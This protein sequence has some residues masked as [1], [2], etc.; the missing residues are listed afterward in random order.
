MSTHTIN[1]SIT[2]TETPITT[3]LVEQQPTILAECLSVVK[4]EGFHM[5]KCIDASL[6]YDAFKHASTMLSELKTTKLLP[7]YYYELYVS[8]FDE[9]R[10]L[11]NYLNEIFKSKSNDL[12]DLYELVQYATSIVPRLYLL[13]T[14][15]SVYMK[16]ANEYY[17]TKL[18]LLPVTNNNDRHANLLNGLA[19]VDLADKDREIPN[20]KKMPPV[21]EIMHDI[22]DMTSG[23]QHA[24]RGLFLRY[25]LSQLT[26]DE[27]PD[28]PESYIPD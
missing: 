23:V 28:I 6:I 16:A 21:K 22:L 17:C 1:S 8:I 3:P 12:S 26:K 4:T 18:I 15:G 10:H 2:E 11:T 20:E 5:R 7:K 24:T 14:V 19:N 25:Y 27:L 13:V 9:L